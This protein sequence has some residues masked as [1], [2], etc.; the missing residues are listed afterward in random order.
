MTSVAA[1][2][3]VYNN[4]FLNID[5]SLVRLGVISIMGDLR[6]L[7]LCVHLGLDLLAVLHLRFL[8]RFLLRSYARI[9]SSS[10]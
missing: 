6:W 3:I 10:V 5:S 7:S 4:L 8:P 9:L 2:E 1:I